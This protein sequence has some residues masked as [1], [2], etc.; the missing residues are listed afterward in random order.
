MD[1][2]VKCKIRENLRSMKSLHA[3]NVK[4][5]EKL[6]DA[7]ENIVVLLQTQG[8]RNEL[9]SNSSLYTMSLEKIHEEMLSQYYRLLG[10]RCKPGSWMRLIIVSKQQKPSRDLK[11][12]IRGLRRI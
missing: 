12:E 2:D 8:K 6:L 9:Q 11:Q 10:E 4:D 5:L 1:Q 7:L 3:D